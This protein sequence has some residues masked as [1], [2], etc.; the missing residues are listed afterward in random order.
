MSALPG[1][2]TGHVGLNVADLERSLGFSPASS[3]VRARAP[4]LVHG[5]PSVGAHSGP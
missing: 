2:T 3:F 4:Y 5:D 1:L